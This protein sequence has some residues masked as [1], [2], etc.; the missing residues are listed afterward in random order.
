MFHGSKVSLAMKLAIPMSGVAR[1]HEIRGSWPAQIV[2][3]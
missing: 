2:Y 3:A 1:G